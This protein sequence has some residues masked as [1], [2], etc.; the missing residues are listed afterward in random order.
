[1]SLIDISHLTFSYEGSG[2]PVFQDLSLQLDTDWRLGFIGRNGRGKTTL[3]RLLMGQGEHTGRISS[4]VAF[5]YFP[6][7]VPDPEADGL[8]VAWALEPELEEWRLVKELRLLGMGE[9]VL[10]RRWDVLSGGERTKLLL[11]L[12]FSREDAFLLVDEPTD[13]LDMAGRELVADYLSRK[14]GFILVSHDRAFL[15]RCVD[16]VLVFNR[17]GLEVQKGNFSTWWENK[18]RR[19]QFERGEQERLRR[20]IRRL[21]EASRR[22]ADWSDAVERSK[23]RSE[24]SGMKVDRGYVGH[25]A[26]KMMKRAKAAEGRRQAAVEEKSQLL[27]DREEAEELKLHPL[28]HPQRRILEARELAPDY[29]QG[30][31]CRPL[32]FTVERGERIA[33]RGANGAGKSSLLKLILGRDVPHR[34]D[35]WR[36]GGTA[37]S[38]LPQDA[39]ALR[40][41]LRAFA[42]E[43]G[44]DES[45]F[46]A[47]LRKLGFERA[48][49]EKD[50]EGYSAGQKK[51]VLL[52]RS[53]CRP[54][55]L[56]LW[57]EPLNFV[58]VY[59]RMQIE[60]LLLRYAPTMVF[61]EHD[62]AFSDKIATRTVEILPPEA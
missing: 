34:G 24:G 5:D 19:E 59:S 2:D 16:H 14:R 4:P 40:G 13:H 9:A 46:K 50:M 47:I 42:E 11:A 44:L 17:T 22:T 32:S 57:D 54:A 8:S 60:S 39:G 48:Q 61:V 53:L 12:L 55:H 28:A 20:D 10:A 43:N 26:A 56:Y 49:F 38:W 29:G 15:D 3:L 31:V 51:K 52:A 6:P 7:A 30:P 33:L 18:E 35:L 36:A 62:R 25:K 41:G 58:D 27:R 45:L 23:Y 37:I 1:M 21:E